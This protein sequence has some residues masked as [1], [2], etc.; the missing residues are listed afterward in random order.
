MATRFRTAPVRREGEDL[1]SLQDTLTGAEALIWPGL[2]NNCIAARLPFSP[3]GR[4][5]S[6]D[7]LDAL[8]SPPTLADLRAHPAFWGIPLLFPFPSRVPRGEYTFEGRRYTM[9]RDFHGFAL[10]TPWRVVDTSADD[11]SARVTSILTSADHPE[12]LDG[13]PF[14]YEIEATHTLDPDGLRLGVRITNAGQGNLPFGYGAHP[15]FRLPLGDR[16]TFGDC[17]IR[18]PA[19]RRWDTRLTTALDAGEVPARDTLC[20][21]AGSAGVPDLRG[22]LPLVEKVYNGVYT[23]LELTGG[24]VECS[25]ADPVNGVEAVMRATPNHPVVV[26]YTHAGAQ[27]VCFEP[28]TCPPNVFNLAARGVPQHGLVVL[29]PG[30]RWHGTMWLSLRPAT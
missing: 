27:S 7:S 13:Y 2:G 12:T 20:P 14:P 9:P 6:P 11:H 30:E 16:G 15:Y 25:V 29:A 19:R 24:L 8:A 3:S 18:V 5:D 4:P 21:P 26:V 10:D 23:E 22:P 17:L 1:V 28:W